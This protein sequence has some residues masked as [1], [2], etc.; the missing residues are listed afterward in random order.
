MKCVWQVCLCENQNILFDGSTL[1]KEASETK[2][3]E[4]MGGNVKH[5]EILYKAT[6]H[7]FGASDFHRQCDNKGPT[8]TVIKR[9]GSPII[10]GGYTPLTG[11]SSETAKAHRG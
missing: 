2:L 1:L 10:F 8:V 4:F 9:N 11:R 7:G 6:Q 5:V 3:A